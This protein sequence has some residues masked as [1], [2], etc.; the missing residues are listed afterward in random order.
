MSTPQQIIDRRFRILWFCALQTDIEKLI[1]AVYRIGLMIDAKHP[2]AIDTLEFY[3]EQIYNMLDE[4]ELEKCFN[5]PEVPIELTV[6][7]NEQ[8]N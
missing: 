4:K 6:V 5:R 1:R 3:E 7:L 8:S 2:K